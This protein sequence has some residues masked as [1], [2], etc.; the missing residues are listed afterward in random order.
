VNLCNDDTKNRS[1]IMVICQEVVEF[2]K[3]LPSLSIRFTGV[4]LRAHLFAK[5]A[6]SDR[7]RCLW[8]HYNVG[9]PAYMLWSDC[10]PIS[11]QYRKLLNLQKKSIVVPY[12][13][14]QI[15]QHKGG[16]K[17]ISSRYLLKT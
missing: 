5:Q 6:S 1:E 14:P 17:F 10:D 15:S 11:N 2:S 9:F 12:C 13:G 8:I 4:M 7:K 3:A 16:T